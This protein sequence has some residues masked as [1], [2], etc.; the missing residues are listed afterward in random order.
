[1]TK[2]CRANPGEFYYVLGAIAKLNDRMWRHRSNFLPMNA[3]VIVILIGAGFGTAV[4][5]MEGLQ[6]AYLSSRVSVSI[7][8]PSR[9]QC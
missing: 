9:S 4:D 7:L 8:S 2:R 1:M 6:P 5:A 3:L